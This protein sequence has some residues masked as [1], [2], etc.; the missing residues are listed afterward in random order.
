[1]EDDCGPPPP[2]LRA[3]LF[4][5]RCPHSQIRQRELNILIERFDEREGK[6]KMKMDSF[7]REVNSRRAADRLLG[8]NAPPSDHD[9]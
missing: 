5:S 1:M 7:Q 3:R 6:F 2:N 8:A 9:D 4:N